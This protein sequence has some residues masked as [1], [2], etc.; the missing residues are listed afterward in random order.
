MEDFSVHPH[1]QAFIRALAMFTEPGCSVVDLG[2]LY[3]DIA[4]AIG[5]RGYRVVGVEG[6]ESSYRRCLSREDVPGNVSFVRSD[7][8]DIRNYGID[9][10]DACVCCGLLYHLD[11]PSGFLRMI[12]PSI[13]HMMIVDTHVSTEHGPHEHSLGDFTSHE[14]LTGRW[15]QDS[16]SSEWGSIG[17]ERSFWPTISSLVGCLVECGFKVV[18]QDLCSRMCL[19]GT[20]NRV[21]I[22]GLRDFWGTN[23]I[24]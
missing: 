9:G 2:C 11:R 5:K 4:V 23:T 17:N 10:F 15:Y 12:S 14:G 6:R 7:V 1:V 22:V 24:T 16:T 20:A 3:G 21:T 13:R 8:R 19:P 18:Y